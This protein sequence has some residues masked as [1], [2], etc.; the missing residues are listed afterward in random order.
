M[1]DF[2]AGFYGFIMNNPSSVWYE[3]FNIGFIVLLGA[4]ILSLYIFYFGLNARSARFNSKKA[5]LMN[6]LVFLL[7]LLIIEAIVAFAIGEFISFDGEVLMFL[8]TNTV[9]FSL[10]YLLFSLIVKRWSVNGSNCPTRFKL[11]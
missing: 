1:S 8:A 7:L 4:I 10:F 3:I 9:Y 5:Y 2:T 11:F 6:L